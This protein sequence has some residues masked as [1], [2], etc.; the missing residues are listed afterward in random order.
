MA[1]TKLRELKTKFESNWINGDFIFGYENEINENHNNNYPLLLVLPPTSELPA[2]EGESIE[3]YT[4][5]CLI[6]KPYYQNQAG[7]LDS[8]FTLLEQEGL[9]WL[10][11][12]LDSYTNKDVILSPDSISVE[13]EKELYNDKLI[14]I[15]LTF[16]LNCFSHHFS[17]NDNL[18][19]SDLSPISWLRSDLGV[20][21]QFSGGVEVISK[22]HDQS[23]NGNHFEQ[24]ATTNMPQYVY[25][26]ADNDYPVLELN[27]TSHF[28]QCVNN[29]MNTV[30][31]SD[32]FT[33]FIVSKTTSSGGVL[34]S[35]GTSSKNFQVATS[36]SDSNFDF[37]FT[38]NND[39]N[40]GSVQSTGNSASSTNVMT[41]T[42]IDDALQIHKN[43][44]FVVFNEDTD[45]QPSTNFGNTSP[46]KIGSIFSGDS[47]FFSGFL[48]EVIIFDSSINESKVKAVS[49]ILKHKYNI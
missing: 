33:I 29:G 16:T 42:L 39:S 9:T 17:Y 36:G 25:D 1:F 31:L 40:S 44:T 6:V 4:F 8:V 12:V 41:F 22:W 45:L 34:L 13:R 23:G 5:E 18:L 2:T 3:E 38:F 43:S 21:T 49:E 28:L 27:G 46:M 10:Q 26:Y 20:K 24:T 15:R 32:R 48:Q 14:Q 11:R 35:K 7:S 47:S 37:S 19:I 30:G